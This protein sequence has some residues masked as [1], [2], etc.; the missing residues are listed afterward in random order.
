MSALSV[1]SAQG[2]QIEALP[3]SR[4]I[5]DIKANSKK[6]RCEKRAIYGNMA[7]VMLR[8]TAGME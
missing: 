2:L 7:L 3:G 4:G 8:G 5:E 1:G 6:I